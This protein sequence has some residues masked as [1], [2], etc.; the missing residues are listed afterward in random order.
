MRREAAIENPGRGG[1]PCAEHEQGQREVR[2]GARA[3]AGVLP[4][5]AE[6]TDE[7]KTQSLRTR[8]LSD[9]PERSEDREPELGEALGRK[10][11]LSR[12]RPGSSCRGRT[13]QRASEGELVRHLPV[14]R[15][16][17]NNDQRTRHRINSSS[18]SAHANCSPINIKPCPSPSST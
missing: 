5:Q 18:K 3:T 10:E 6:L 9:A 4:G 15:P 14:T 8:R 11:G 17:A 7:D 1:S 16:P 13:Y 12:A 2:A